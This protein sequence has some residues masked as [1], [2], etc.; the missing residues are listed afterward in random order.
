MN[1][2]VITSSA[3]SQSL[4]RMLAHQVVAAIRATGRRA[5]YGT[6]VIAHLV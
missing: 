2:H 4:S 3:N 1:I 6:F 5:T